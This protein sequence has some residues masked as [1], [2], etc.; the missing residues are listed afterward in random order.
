[1][2]QPTQRPCGAPQGRCCPQEQSTA[3]K[4]CGKADCAPTAVLHRGRRGERR[5]G[6]AACC[7]LDPKATRGARPPEQSIRVARV[8]RAPLETCSQHSVVV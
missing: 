8:A 2:S 1:A 3:Q 7:P 5:E 6:E 4:R